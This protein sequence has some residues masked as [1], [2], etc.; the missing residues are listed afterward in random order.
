MIITIFLV[1]IRNSLAHDNYEFVDIA[2]KIRYNDEDKTLEESVGESASKLLIVDSQKEI[3]KNLIKQ[4]RSQ[5]SIDNLTEK[6][7]EMFDFFFGGKYDFKD[8]V[9]VMNE[10]Q[11]TPNEKE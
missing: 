4:N 1:Q 9:D 10:Y 6:F 8:I 2:Q 7:K 5:A 3:L 11:E